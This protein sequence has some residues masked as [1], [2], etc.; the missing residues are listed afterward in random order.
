MRVMKFFRKNTKWMMA[1]FGSLLMVMFL[2]PTTPSNQSGGP[3]YVRATFV[4][5]TGETREIR[6]Q[7]LQNRNNELNILNEI[8]FS[9]FFESAVSLTLPGS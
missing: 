4:D 7:D 9:F 6:I 8:G 1:I 2:L 5:A 3:D